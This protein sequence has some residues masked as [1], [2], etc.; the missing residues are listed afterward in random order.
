[1]QN[2]SLREEGSRFFLIS[3]INRLLTINIK[4]AFY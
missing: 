4:L 2:G 1:M 3:L